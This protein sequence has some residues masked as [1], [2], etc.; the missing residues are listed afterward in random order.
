[1]NVRRSLDHLVRAQQQRLWDRQAERLGRLEVDR[2]IEPSGLRCYFISPQKM[3]QF[4][5]AGLVRKTIAY[6]PALIGIR[7]E[8]A[9]RPARSR[10]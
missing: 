4:P 10:W 9:G 2:Q 8:C 5:S 7:P 1:M 3:S 6:S